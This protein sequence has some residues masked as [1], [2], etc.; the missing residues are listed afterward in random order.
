MLFQGKGYLPIYRLREELMLGERII[1]IRQ[2][3]HLKQNDFAARLQ[4]KA[5][6]VS[7]MESNRIKPSL[8]TLLAI[9][10]TFGINLHWLLTGNG[11]MLAASG[12]G[13]KPV[14][15][16]LQDLQNILNQQLHEIIQSKDDMYQN[17]IASIRVSGEIAAGLPVESIDT[18]L[19][20]ITVKRAIIHGK[21]EEYISLRV[22]G[23]SM[24]P[25]IRHND[26]VLIRQNNDWQKLSGKI[27]AVRI[28][29]SITLKKLT[30]DDAQ[31]MIVLVSL[32]EE[33]SPIL[34]HPDEHQDINL[35]GYLYFLYRKL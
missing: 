17:E 3:Y 35:I 24:E 7:Q 1:A 20:L 16:K 13:I 28:D 18:E 12:S 8:D 4:I 21:I 19:D 6:A 29:G 25:D 11:E 23:H 10:K 33:Y 34:V 15:Q 27:C 31:Q 14:S 5:S 32:N 2:N 30:L 9:T 22:N 26:V